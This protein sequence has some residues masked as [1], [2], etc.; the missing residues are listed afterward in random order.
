[1]EV[2]IGRFYGYEPEKKPVDIILALLTAWGCRSG[3]KVEPSFLQRFIFRM[4]QKA[5]DLMVDVS[6]STSSFQ[7][8]SEDVDLALHELQGAGFL[9]RPNPIYSPFAISAQKAIFADWM[10]NENKDD[11]Q[12]FAAELGKE[13]C[14][15]Q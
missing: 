10:T 2:Q 5:P 15:A 7:P 9:V 4:K 14:D 6:F 13:L 3:Q 1:M 11:I 8:Y 12:R